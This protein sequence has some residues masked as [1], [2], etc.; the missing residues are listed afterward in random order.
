MSRPYRKHF[1][2]YGQH[3]LNSKKRGIPFLL[4]FEEWLDIWTAS[5]HLSERGRGAGKYVMARF[6]DT[7]PYSKTNVSIQ[8]YLQ[9]ASD[10]TLGKKIIN[11]KSSGP[12]PWQRILNQRSTFAIK[13]GR[14]CP[15]P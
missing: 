13:S 12:H 10:A 1:K 8:S 15:L 9:N 4:T 7:G 5:G 6:G 2:Q 14:A 11:R 3:R